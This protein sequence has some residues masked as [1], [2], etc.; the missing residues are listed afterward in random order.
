[1]SRFTVWT[2]FSFFVIGASFLTFFTGNKPANALTSLSFQST[3]SAQTFSG[4]ILIDEEEQG[5]P[6]NNFFISLYPD[7]VEE[8]NVTDGGNSLS[9]ADLNLG[10]VNRISRGRD[11]LSFLSDTREL[12]TFSFDDSQQFGS[13]TDLEA[14]LASLDGAKAIVTSSLFPQFKREVVF[15]L[16]TKEIPESSTLFGLLAVASLGTMAKLNSYKNS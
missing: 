5:L 2:K 8:F 9:L 15:S 4:N 6:Q 11:F 7:A 1:M 13:A 3:N 16:P 14:V 10:V 12:A